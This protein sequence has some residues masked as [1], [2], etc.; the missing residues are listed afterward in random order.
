MCQSKDSMYQTNVSIYQKL[1][2]MYQSNVL[3]VSLVNLSFPNPRQKCDPRI[4]CDPEI[5]TTYD[6][7]DELG[8]RG[9]RLVLFF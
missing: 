5:V 7:L 8:N 6:S 2:S 9:N 4:E 3:S 1:N